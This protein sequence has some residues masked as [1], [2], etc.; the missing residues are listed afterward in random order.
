MEYKTRDFGVVDIAP[1]R[2]I[3]MADPIFGFESYRRFTLL[4]DE[5]TGCDITFLQSLDEPGLCFIILDP[6][7]VCE[8]YAP[9]IPEHI[10]DKL[11]D[12]EY[13]VRVIASVPLDFAK[14]TV[15]L[16]SPLVINLDTRRASQVILEQNYPVRQPIAKEAE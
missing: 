15:N 7:A 2:E 1:E 4:H 16:K 10:L 3:T 6:L 12:G 14:T 8:D 9:E 13:A 11:G 5:E